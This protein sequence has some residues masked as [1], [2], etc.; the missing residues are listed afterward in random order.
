M[1]VTHWISIAQV[2]AT[3]FVGIVAG[4]ITWKMQSKQI[5]I[6]K[7][8]QEIARA[9]HETAA[10]KLRLELFET[11]FEA[12]KEVLSHI[13]TAINYDYYKNEVD[14]KILFEEHKNSCAPMKFLFN[15]YIHDYLTNDVTELM[16]NYLDASDAYGYKGRIEHDIDSRREQFKSSRSSLIKSLKTIDIMVSPYLQVEKEKPLIEQDDQS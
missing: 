9:Q 11:R 7:G 6:A 5:D 13:K 2:G 14:V 10:T 4:F 8:L 16:K 12:Y 1:N 3:A 15:E